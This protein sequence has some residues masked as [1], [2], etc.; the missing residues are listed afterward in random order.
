MQETLYWTVVTV[1]SI[2]DMGC[3]SLYISQQMPADAR[4]SIS[5]SG[6]KTLYIR[7]QM[8]DT[9]YQTVDAGVS[10]SDRGCKRLYISDSGCKR[11]YQTANARVSIS[12]SGY[13]CLYIRK[14]MQKTLSD[15]MQEFLYQ[16]ADARN[17]NRQRML[18]TL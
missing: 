10:I 2:S 13:S 1:D 6:C 4:D 14:R 17:Y 7:Q 8:Q 12:H 3:R 5:D 9:L 16:T 11:L 15:R 18:D